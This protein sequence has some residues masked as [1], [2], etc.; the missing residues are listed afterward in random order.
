MQSKS[1]IKALVFELFNFVYRGL[2]IHDGSFRSYK[3][4]FC[5]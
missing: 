2:K 5:N 4:Y 3:N 1:K